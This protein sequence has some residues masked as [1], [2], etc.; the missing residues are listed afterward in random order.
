MKES[1]DPLCYSTNMYLSSF[2]GYEKMTVISWWWIM[3]FMM[4]MMM[5]MCVGCRYLGL[6]VVFKVMGMA[7]LALI[8]WKVGRTREYSLEKRPEGALWC[9]SSSQRAHSVEDTVFKS[10]FSKPDQWHLLLHAI[11][12]HGPDESVSW[13]YMDGC[14]LPLCTDILQPYAIDKPF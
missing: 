12:I 1:S 13:S 8:S 10:P 4:M 9:C 2:Y 11:F 6:Q 5:V 3:I 7:M 14:Y